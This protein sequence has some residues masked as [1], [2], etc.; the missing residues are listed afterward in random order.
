MQNDK[1]FIN[2]KRWYKFVLSQEEVQA[3][4]K[5]LPKDIDIKPIKYEEKVEKSSTPRDPPKKTKGEHQVK[6]T[7]DEGK[8]VDLPGEFYKKELRVKGCQNPHGYGGVLTFEN[9][10][11]LLKGV[12][13]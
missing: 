12:G 13:G 5:A 2:I 9:P 8:F 3:V 11:C 6:Q 1:G 10:A 7:K 4:V